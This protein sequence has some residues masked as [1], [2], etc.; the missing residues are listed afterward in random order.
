MLAAAPAK[1]PPMVQMEMP[2]SAPPADLRYGNW[3]VRDSGDYIG[4][5]TNNASGSAFGVLCG[6][7]CVLYVNMQKTCEPGVSYPAMLN[8]P[9]GAMHINWRCHLI[10]DRHIYIVDATQE[11]F[12]ILEGGGEIGFALPLANGQFAVS[13]F[14]L[15]GGYQAAM[16]AVETAAGRGGRSQQG[17]R[18]FTI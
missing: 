17:L 4:A 16:K 12:D 14:S 11:Y 1:P 15:T 10:E 3:L 5:W 2:S 8:S 7:T 6:R 18:D 13:R 9:K